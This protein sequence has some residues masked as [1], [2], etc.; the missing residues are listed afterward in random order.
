M[1]VIIKDSNGQ[2]VE[3]FK[4]GVS[5]VAT[6]GNTTAAT[7]AF[8]ATTTMVRVAASLGHC[9]VAFGANPTASITTSA[10]I[11]NNSSEVFAVSPG[12]KM[13]YIKDVTVT[14]STV[15][16]TELL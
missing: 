4:L 5:Q 15:C 16:V 6:V 12:D 9:H 11:P 8:G 3:A 2:L 1:S 14:S 7:T 10:M 13:A